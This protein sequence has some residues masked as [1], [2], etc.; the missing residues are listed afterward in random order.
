M[1][2]IATLRARYP[3]ADPPS[4]IA[5]FLILHELT[6]IVPLFAGFWAFKAAGVG[7]GLVAWAV[8]DDGEEEQASW[9]RAKFRQWVTDGEEQAQK[10]GR[11]YG[12][13][14]IEKESKEQKEER[15]QREKD[16]VVDVERAPTTYSVGGDVANLV[17]AYIAVKALLPLRILFSLRAA[18]PMANVIARRFKGLREVG[19]RYLKKQA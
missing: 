18:P 6:A 19:A 9:S 16:G 3:S 5:S 4:L 10:I 17:A 7:A 12:A 15:K 1:P 11:R 14:G 13:F 2:Y 8:A